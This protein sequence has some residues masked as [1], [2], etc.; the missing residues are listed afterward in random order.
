MNRMICFHK[1]LVSQSLSWKDKLIKD[2]IA[3]AFDTLILWCTVYMK[4]RTS[5]S[6]SPTELCPL[7][8][9]VVC[10]FVTGNKKSPFL[11]SKNVLIICFLYERIAVP[12]SWF[13][14]YRQRIMTNK[15]KV[16]MIKYKRKNEKKNLS[17]L[18]VLFFE[19]SVDVS[20]LL[21]GFD[22]GSTLIWMVCLRSAIGSAS[23]SFGFTFLRVA[24]AWTNLWTQS[25]TGFVLLWWQLMLNVVANTIRVL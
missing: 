18:S 8:C 19:S 11:L 24:H 4:W 10:Y 3:S 13:S 12:C 1:M 6:M 20:V 21:A 5:W 16:E 7:F 22:R 23:L 2:A 9:S 25:F 14:T 15:T 17:E